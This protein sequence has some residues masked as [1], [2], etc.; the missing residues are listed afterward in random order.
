MRAERDNR[1]IQKAAVQLQEATEQ[2]WLDNV[3]RL[4]ENEPPALSIAELKA[5]L[6]VLVAFL[7]MAPNEECQ[8]FIQTRMDRIRE[9]LSKA[10][11]KPLFV[12]RPP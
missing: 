5:L 3:T 10:V 6:T 9:Y 11:E 4:T 7:A 2:K 8:K 1:Q 12:V